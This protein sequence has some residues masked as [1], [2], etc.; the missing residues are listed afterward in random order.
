MTLRHKPFVLIEP[1][2][3]P[4]D[5]WSCWNLL[6]DCRNLLTVL[7]GLP[8]YP[9][10]IQAW[11]VGG[12]NG[13]ESPPPP[14]LDV[15]HRSRYPKSIRRTIW[16]FDMPVPFESIGKDRVRAVLSS[17]LDH[18]EDLG[19]VYSLLA[20]TYYD[21]LMKVEMR[22]FSARTSPRNLSPSAL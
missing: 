7:I 22:V 1:V 17:W 11:A 9:T 10:V 21:P 5:Y 4:L 12:S 13:E 20:E 14:T 6:S 3:E 8:V 18:A 19:P 15:Y 2:G 16:A